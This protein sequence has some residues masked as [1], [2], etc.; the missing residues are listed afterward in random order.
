MLIGLTISLIGVVTLNR[1]FGIVPALR[2]VQT[3]GSYR[4]IRHPMY[5][6]GLCTVLGYVMGNLSW[7]NIAIGVATLLLVLLRIRR[8]EKFLLQN[9]EAYQHYVEGVRFKLIPFVY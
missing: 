3:G 6:G 1:S 8:E 4:Y 5:A 9:N 2:R 7:L